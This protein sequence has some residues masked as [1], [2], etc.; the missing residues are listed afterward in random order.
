MRD[1][2]G[3]DDGGEGVD[4]TRTV[5]KIGLASICVN[6]AVLRVLRDA[7][8][9]MDRIVA[10]TYQLLNLHVRRLLEAR[11]EVPP[12]TRNYLQSFALAV[13][14]GER[15]AKLPPE[16]AESFELYL[17]TRT[18]GYELPSR[19]GLSQAIADACV[20]IE[21][22]IRNNIAVHFFARQ[23]KHL[24]YVDEDTPPSSTDREIA[25]RQ[26]QINDAAA[27]R[28]DLDELTL[29]NS[30][31][32]SVAYDLVARPWAFLAPMWRMRRAAERLYEL[33]VEQ[34]RA[35]AR[36]AGRWPRNVRKNNNFALLPLRRG[37]V[38]HAFAVD[39]D[40]LFSLFSNDLPSD[41]PYRVARRVRDQARADNKTQRNRMM[42]RGAD[43]ACSNAADDTERSRIRRATEVAK[44]RRQRDD[45][46]DMREERDALWYSLFNRRRLQVGAGNRWT[47]SHRIQTDG[48]S[49]SV[50]Y[51][52]TPES[53]P[54]SV[55]S[56][57]PKCPSKRKRMRSDEDAN[58]LPPLPDLTGR[59]VVGVDPGMVDL[60]SC[61]SDDATKTGARLRYTAVQRRKEGGAKRAARMRQENLDRNPDAKRAQA[62]LG[63]A[64]SRDSRSDLFAGYLRKQ[65]AA[66]E[67]L[68][69]HYADDHRYRALRWS[70]F[71][72]RQRSEARLVRNM[73]RKFGNDA[74]LA[75]GAW[76]KPA[77]F[78]IK[79]TVGGPG[80]GLR[81]MLSK[82]FTVVVVPEWHTTE[83]CHRCFRRGQV[84]KMGEVKKRP[85]MSPRWGHLK[86]EKRPL[87]D[88][89][90]LRRCQNAKCGVWMNRD[91]NA[92]M[93][94]RANLMHR[95]AYGCYHPAFASTYGH[96]HPAAN[97]S[98][99]AVE[100]PR[101]KHVRIAA[102]ECVPD[103]GLDV[104]IV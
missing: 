78:A 88:V 68:L 53:P 93:N 72:H 61:T 21:T 97:E 51:V 98:D 42:D 14:R 45:P 32:V 65:F 38:P 92:A 44:L 36:T 77:G 23:F 9:R 56:A 81:R 17:S 8:P 40:T 43:E 6:T 3:N 37:F 90:A 71:R 19:C 95:A 1:G 13:S 89:R 70:C 55:A 48:V 5:V 35:S 104:S 50:H 41:H 46:N 76:A 67:P 39:T 24:R 20:E 57:K 60:I 11:Q 52:R 103:D 84:G 75:Y 12:L 34:E 69:R 101:A 63:D 66:Q 2:D 102:G 30:I 28:D 33:E 83:T 100:E 18:P 94:I 16:L 82:H 26:R 64:D 31:D 96:H 25:A 62:A 47:F 4:A 54:K 10:E 74:V 27:N 29:P 79:G 80:V 7:A 58:V 15:P 85:S 73:K 87:V 91:Y 86:K 22:A 99:Q 59:V 49:A